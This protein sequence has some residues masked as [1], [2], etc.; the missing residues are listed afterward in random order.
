MKI[1]ELVY[2]LP[3]GADERML[4]NHLLDALIQGILSR[5]TYLEYLEATQGDVFD[6]IEDI[7]F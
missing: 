5:E 7:D 1:K 2:Q 4:N 6:L 3:Y